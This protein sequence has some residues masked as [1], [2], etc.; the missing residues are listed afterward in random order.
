MIFADYNLLRDL[1]L[2]A[3]R[4][5]LLK[6]SMGAQLPVFF[7]PFPS[8]SPSAVPSIPLFPAFPPATAKGSGGNA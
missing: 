7:S 3:H 5:R 8:S 4:H 1:L 2:V 6:T